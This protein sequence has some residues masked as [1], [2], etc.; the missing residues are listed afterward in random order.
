[1]YI[2]SF[3]KVEY[4]VSMQDELTYLILQ[5]VF[6][7]AAKKKKV[8]FLVAGPLRGGGVTS[9]V[10]VLTE[11]IEIQYLIPRKKNLCGIQVKTIPI[12]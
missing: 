7:E 8:H 10:R 9:G 6:R 12:K 11:S 1:M 3:S 5:S 4:N 2:I